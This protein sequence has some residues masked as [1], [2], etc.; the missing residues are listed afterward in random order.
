MRVE[1][2]PHTPPSPAPAP[3]PDLPR[4]DVLGIPLALTDYEGTMDWMDS[5]IASGHRACLSAAAVH[6]VMV[7]QE[8]PTTREAVL[9]SMAVPDGQPLVWAL[10]ALGHQQASRIYGPELMARFC[11]RSARTG[12]RMYFYGGRNQGALVQ[13]VLNLRRRFPGIRI[14]GGYSPPFRPLDDEERRAVADE[15]NRSRAD[16]V[17]VGIGQPKQERW[18]EDM[19]QLLDPPVMVGVGAAFDFHAGLVPQAPSW[20]QAS[21]LEWAFRL[22]QEPRRLWRRY[23]RYNPRFV[24]GFARQLAAQRAGR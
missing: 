21:G 17:W 7:A 16:V 15:I 10:R 24:A 22:V 13:L 11:E 14:V 19:R 4:A 20:V 8:D 3:A 18:M 5:T 9:R 12:T 2:H 23:A 6:L 1:P